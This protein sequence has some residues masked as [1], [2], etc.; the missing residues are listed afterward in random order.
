MSPASSVRN[1]LLGI[2]Y[3]S[4]VPQRACAACCAISRRR[5]A[6]SLAARALPP[7]F[8]SLIASFF[9]IGLAVFDLAGGDVDDQLLSSIGS[10]GRL[11]RFVLI[12]EKW[13]ACWQRQTR[14]RRRSDICYMQTDPLPVIDCVGKG[15]HP[16][17]IAR[18]RDAFGVDRMIRVTA[19]SCSR[20]PKP[21][22]RPRS[23]EKLVAGSRDGDEAGN[24]LRRVRQSE[25]C[26][27]A[28]PGSF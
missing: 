22:S 20:S 23:A 27:P 2:G 14:R 25:E 19:W 28:G 24:G 15:G 16:A 9:L 18:L 8:A 11:R 17:D 4:A 21:A 6:E 12:P 7:F 26:E 5:F 3:L 13:H 10:R 1:A